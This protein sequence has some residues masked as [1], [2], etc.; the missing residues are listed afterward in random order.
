MSQQSK[1]NIFVKTGSDG[2]NLRRNF[3]L[4]SEASAEV[5]LDSA[6][7]VFVLHTAKLVWTHTGLVLLLIQILLSYK[8]SLCTF[9]YVSFHVCRVMFS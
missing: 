2:G 3:N 9:M 4:K 8:G 1:D 6:L 5:S 7:V